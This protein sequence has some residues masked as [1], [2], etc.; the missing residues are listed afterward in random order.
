[1]L[2]CNYAWWNAQGAG[3]EK[4]DDVEGIGQRT[5]SCASFLFARFGAVIAAVAS[6]G[7]GAR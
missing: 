6:S 5:R 1:M 4:F 7:L 2:G 3:L